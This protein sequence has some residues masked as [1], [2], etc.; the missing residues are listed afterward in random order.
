M[1]EKREMT[2]KEI[3]L[4]MY[5]EVKDIACVITLEIKMPTGEVEFITNPNVVDKIEYIKKTYNDELVHNGCKDI[6]IL[7][8]KF[9]CTTD[10]FDFGQAIGLMKAGGK[11][12]RKGWNGKGIYIQIYKPECELEGVAEAVHNAWWEEKKKQGVTDHPD[13]IPYNELEEDVKEYDRVTAKATIESLTYMT[14]PFI[15]IVTNGLVTENP[16]APKGIVPWLASQTDMLAN[17]WVVVRD[18]E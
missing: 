18:Q 3:F 14:Q 13:M 16:D 7:H 17:D 6:Q 9:G 4:A 15:Y 8:A 10:T 5:E 12:A 1:T 2:K 11:V